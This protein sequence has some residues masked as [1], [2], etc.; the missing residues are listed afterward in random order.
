MKNIGNMNNDQNNSFAPRQPLIKSYGWLRIQYGPKAA[1]AAQEKA[2]WLVGLAPWTWEATMTFRKPLSSS[3]AASKFASFMRR[4]SRVSYYYSVERDPGERSHHIH[5][6]LT[7]V[8]E[9]SQLQII[10]GWRISFGHVDMA[11]PRR[12]LDLAH[13]LSKVI[14][15]PA[16][17]WDVHLTSKRKRLLDAKPEKTV[18]HQ[19]GQHSLLRP[20][21]G[22]Q[23][24]PAPDGP[25]RLT[26]VGQARMD[27]APAHHAAGVSASRGNE[28][29]QHDPAADSH[30]SGAGESADSVDAPR[31]TSRFVSPNPN[32][33]QSSKDK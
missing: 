19:G 17:E 21:P 12:P 7:D 22:G 6:L 20:V 5:A 16:G 26:R 23:C 3:R 15:T 31:D 8:T 14:G 10:K 11:I 30:N 1:M 24:G 25:G 28:P 13:Y 4:F 2:E 18:S 33:R 9:M 27:P 29:G 32:N